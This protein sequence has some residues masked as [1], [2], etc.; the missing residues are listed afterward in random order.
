MTY[1]FDFFLIVFT[2]E[3][4]FPNVLIVIQSPYIE[5]VLLCGYLYKGILHGAT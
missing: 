3:T 4:I 1:F 2:K 5:N